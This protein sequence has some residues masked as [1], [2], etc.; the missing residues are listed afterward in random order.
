MMPNHQLIK[1]DARM[2]PLPDKSVHL[3]VTSP[4]YYNAREYTASPAEIGRSERGGLIGYFN[5]LQKCFREVHRVLRDDGTLIVNIGDTYL[6]KQLLGVPW[7]LALLLRNSL[8]FL[9]R[10]DGIWHKTNGFPDSAQ[11]RPE[12][13]HEYVFLFSKG[14]KYYWDK[15]AVSRAER[16]SVRACAVARSKVAH[17]A[18]YP[19][20]LILPFLRMATS[21]FGVCPSCGAPWTRVVEKTRTPTRPGRNNTADPTGKAK[22]DHRRHVTTVR[23]VGWAPVCDCDPDS[24]RERRDS[25]VPATVLDP[26]AG[27]CTT[28]VA[29]EWTGRDSIMVDLAEDFLSF[30]RHRIATEVPPRPRRASTTGTLVP[31]PGQQVFPWYGFDTPCSRPMY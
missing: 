1:A 19:P 21:E 22:R 31:L 12:A 14:R 6:D 4:P 17:F 13:M 29:A 26:F 20:Q 15:H 25:V 24:N 28:A 10:S 16:L 3:C 9:I 8:G 27:T 23:T 7:Q 30:G 18:T 11:D 2:L 5:A